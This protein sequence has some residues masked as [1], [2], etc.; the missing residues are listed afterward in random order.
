MGG[1]SSTLKVDSKV[2]KKAYFHENN[3]KPF[4]N[5]L[6]IVSHENNE[7]LS[8][9][10]IDPKLFKSLYG[11]EF[12]LKNTNNFYDI[13]R[14]S[15]SNEVNCCLINKTYYTN[16]DYK[17]KSCDPNVHTF[18]S[19]L[20]DYV[21][22]DL[23]LQ[24]EHPKCKAWVRSVVEL[25]KPYFN[26]ILRYISEEDNR[27]KEI[28]QV[29]INALYDFSNNKNNY[30]EIIDNILNSYSDTIKTNEYKCAF[31]P[32]EILDLEK[33]LKTPRECWYKE[34]VLSPTHKL[35][36]GNYYKRSQCH[37]TIC[38]INIKN[39]QISNN[40]IEIICNNS[41][42]KIKQNLLYTNPLQTDKTDIIFIPTYLNTI[43]PLLL[44]LSILFI[45]IK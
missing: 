23:C 16:S 14:K 44:I 34:C 42:N 36:S 25:N 26:D 37:I 9:G 19:N 30:L 40:K 3:V 5:N 11:D 29:F 6:A 35:L 2:W 31:P 7:Y 18:N 12:E 8:I 1:E 17:I 20:C 24:S 13:Y 4:E 39:L 28:T 38:D 33:R 27:N 22:K 21:F 43:L 32:T 10:K 41:K 45:K 15:Y